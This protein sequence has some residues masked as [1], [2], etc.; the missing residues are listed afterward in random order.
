MDGTLIGA[1]YRIVR[2]LAEGGMSVV[3]E[4]VHERTG[5]T[6]AL[7]VLS[8]GVFG[9]RRQDFVARFEREAKASANLET[10]HVVPVLDAG[11]SDDGAPFLV[12]DLL[13][14]ADV[15][16]TVETLGPLQPG[17]A[18]RIAM[19]ACTGLAAAHAAGV[20]HRDVKSANLFLAETH[21]GRIEVK[22][23]DFGIAKL[24][25]DAASEGLPLTQTGSVLGSPL[26]MSPEQALDAKN[27]DARTDLWSLGVVLY[28][29]LAGATP[30]ADVGSLPR[31]LL[32]ITQ[33]GA[34]S[35]RLAAPW[36]PPALAMLV[37]RAL[38]I[39]REAR[40]ASAGEMR[41]ALAPLAPDGAPL[42]RDA[43]RPVPPEVRS[44]APPS[45][46]AR[47]IEA[48]PR[49][50]SVRRSIAVLG[51]RM[52]TKEPAEAWLSTA[53]VEM[54]TA[55]LS[56]GEMLRTVPGE[57]VERA[58]RELQLT[59]DDLSKPEATA[60]LRANLGTDFVLTG[61][62]LVEAAPDGSR[63]RLHLSLVGDPNEPLSPIVQD[64]VT[65]DLV[66][67]VASSGAK[68]RQR[69]GVRELSESEQGQL[70]AALAAAP[71]VL[72]LYARGLDEQRLGR[73]L[74]ARSLLERAVAVDP[75][76]S[77]GYAALARA[78][79]GV[80]LEEDA[81]RMAKAALDRSAGLSREQKLWVEA[82]HAFSRNDFD[83]AADRY[84]AL[85]TFFPDNVD[86]G[87][88]LAQVLC[89]AGRPLDALRAVEQLRELPPSLS[90][91]PRIDYE[92][93]RAAHSLSDH[94]RT[95]RAAGL[96]IEKARARQNRF[97]VGQALYFYGGGLV[98]TGRPA[99][100]LAA[101]EEARRV[102][103][104]AGDRRQVAM[105][106]LTICE[107]LVPVGELARAR[108]AVEEAS[109]QLSELAAPNWA[110]SVLDHHALVDVVQ[111]DLEA[112]VRRLEEA[113]HIYRAA[114]RKHGLGNALRQLAEARLFLGDLPG[115][116][117]AAEES[118]RIA[119]VSGRKAVQAQAHLVLAAL[120]ARDG[121]RATEQRLQD[122]A[123]ELAGSI[124]D[125]SVVALALLEVGERQRQKGERE[126]AR[127]TL[128]RALAT[129]AEA[130]ER[131]Y[132]AD[133][134]RALARLA[135]DE[136]RVED[137]RS[138]ASEALA[139]YRT[140]G[141]RRGETLAEELLRSPAAKR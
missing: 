110:A 32:A 91:D 140:A 42:T 64:G 82:V 95:V 84:R 38:S 35:V 126:A 39:P 134:Q 88:L 53:L 78:L 77:L 45:P 85:F 70:R 43:L 129:W 123:L 37:S 97:L 31:L 72:E 116:A 46:L 50:H 68:L 1:K 34:P 23:L 106:D 67:L 20:I 62:Y 127:A 18:V 63:I 21:D 51:L 128:E 75:G 93:A 71:E 122:R 2:P 30:F 83:R 54:L 22:I 56:A 108:A 52:L 113:A 118:L 79:I 119:T 103:L 16:K 59:D 73:V 131:L 139:F 6:V 141:A 57:R 133:A 107:S 13:R 74:S 44:T 41:E 100:G 120:A 19:Q 87:L 26:Y 4:A 137:A 98:G 24:R 9:L 109:E 104:E 94:A 65:T 33:Q 136:G 49:S 40:F 138:L 121:D 55:E 28:E 10:P 86:Y 8:P 17:I 29:M 96:S 25:L 114:D 115:A 132:A 48:S 61:S 47:T 124:G 36:V 92:E 3:Y 101:F 102:A 58:K 15:Q 60:L 80:G 130:G 105:L 125:K 99:E 14:G 27:I 81:E 135:L 66:S 7:K 69:L 112:A 5:R 12:M 76:F 11:V 89:Y 90:D 111:G 117:E